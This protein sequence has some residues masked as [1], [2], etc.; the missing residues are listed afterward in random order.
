MGEIGMH[1]ADARNSGLP[2][3]DGSAKGTLIQTGVLEAMLLSKPSKTDGKSSWVTADSLPASAVAQRCHTS[4]LHILSASAGRHGADGDI[5]FD[6]RAASLEHTFT[7]VQVPSISQMAECVTPLLYSIAGFVAGGAPSDFVHLICLSHSINEQLKPASNS[8]WLRMYA[9]RWPAFFKCM[10]FQGCRDWRKLY[11]ETFLGRRECILEIFDREKKAGFAMAAMAAQVQFV[12]G[13][14][15]YIARYLSASHVHPET[16]PM[17][18][19]A[20]LRFCPKNV[21]GQLQPG[22]YLS[23]DAKG[24]A[25]KAKLPYPHR[26]LEGT[27]GLRIGNGVEL[28]WKMQV[29]SPFGWWY[30]RLEKLEHVEGGRLAH[31]TIIFHHFPENSRWYRLSILFGDAEMR[32]CSFGGHTG[33]IRPCT[34]AEMEQ[35]QQFFPVRPVVF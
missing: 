35:W 32:P 8:L 4:P 5:G 1:S 24:V 10:R 3:W 12:S 16:I 31:A 21:R 14:N 9:S 19:S 6:S 11:W 26:V 17:A 23:S 33:G 34:E 27:D 22:R 15:V 25:G 30:G 28:Q 29:G 20:R 13:Q 7:S 2:E 18:E